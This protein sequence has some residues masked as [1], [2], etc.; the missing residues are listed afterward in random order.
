MSRMNRSRKTWVL[1]LLGLVALILVSGL[2]ALEPSGTP[3]YWV[4]R[5]A[6]LLGYLAVFLSI[7]SSATMRQMVRIFG[8]PFVKIHHALSIAGLTLITL[9]P[10]AVAWAYASPRIL[11]PTFDSWTLFFQFGGSVAWPLIAAASL[12]AVLRQAVGRNWRVAHYLN[13]VAFWLATVHANMIGTDFQHTVVR[14]ISV[15]MSLAV[16]A[17]FVQKRLR[18]RRR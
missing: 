3:L 18:T 4:I 12:A 10:L 8:R 15:V 6:S 16:I 14:A 9:H 17:I 1:A 11:L 2:I 13:Y 7:V 5:A